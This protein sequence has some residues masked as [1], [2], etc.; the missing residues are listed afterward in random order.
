MF[1][2][3]FISQN[4]KQLKQV[5]SELASVATVKCDF[6]GRKFKSFRFDKDDTQKRKQRQN[7]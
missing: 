5:H 7:I 4:S 6:V 3:K 2:L 1:Y